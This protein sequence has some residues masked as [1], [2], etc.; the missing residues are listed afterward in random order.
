MAV[1]YDKLQIMCFQVCLTDTI[2][3][4]M[5]HTMIESVTC[6]LTDEAWSRKYALQIKY[7]QLKTSKLAYISKVTELIRSWSLCNLR[8]KI[9]IQ[10]K[11][12]GRKNKSDKYIW[13]WLCE[14]R[15]EPGV[16]SSEAGL[17]AWI[18]HFFSQLETEVPCIDLKVMHSWL[19]P[20]QHTINEFPYKITEQ[21]LSHLNFNH[22]AQMIESWKGTLKYQIGYNEMPIKL[23]SSQKVFDAFP[24]YR[25]EYNIRKH[26]IIHW[27]RKL[28]RNQRGWSRMETTLEAAAHFHREICSK[29]RWEHGTCN[30][31]E[32]ATHYIIP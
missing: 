12:Q 17:Q 22:L 10:K 20:A 23:Q 30:F 31:T 21:K 32:L 6:W 29:Q 8:T 16:P 9:S 27:R 3:T 28:H 18:E 14:P 11:K 26:V 7:P 2:L 25:D 4:S 1:D 13:Q 24:S 15:H 19:D 5:L